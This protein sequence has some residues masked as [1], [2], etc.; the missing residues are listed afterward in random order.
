MKNKSLR[1]ATRRSRL[2]LWQA[3]HV[4]SLLSSRYPDLDVSLIP[5]TTRGDIEL[6]RS[7]LEIG[8]KGLFLKELER[9]LLDGEADIAVHSLKDVPAEMTPGLQLPVFLPREVPD[10]AWIG[11]R[12]N[13]PRSMPSGARVGTS[14]LRRQAQLLAVRPDLEV[15]PLR[16][17]VETRLRRLDDGDYAAIILAR[18]GMRRLGFEERMTSALVPP[19]WLPAPGQGVICVQCREGDDEITTRIEA[20]NCAETATAA[21]AERAVVAGLG[22]DCRMPLAALA[23][24]QG[25]EVSL[26][27]RLLD[28]TG[29]RC[30]ESRQQGVVERAEVLGACAAEA[31]LNE[32]GRRIIEALD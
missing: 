20:L 14:S 10:D 8:G 27:A 29:N 15:A 32:G 30:I 6:D 26:T 16:G 2:A 25:H 12:G 9:A 13:T 1:I 31:I 5:L 23:R 22:G 28:P 18:A 21:R 24:I 17:N 11:T 7:L 3:E 19:D 4:A